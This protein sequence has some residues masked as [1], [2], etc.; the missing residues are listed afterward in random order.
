MFPSPSAPRVYPPKFCGKILK[1]RDALLAGR[2]FLPKVGLD[3]YRVYI[4]WGL[5]GFSPTIIYL[6]F[7]RGHMFILLYQSDSIHENTV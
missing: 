2:P 6:V 5:Q 1:L 7:V 3:V 4:Q